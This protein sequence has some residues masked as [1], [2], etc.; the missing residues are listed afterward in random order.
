MVVYV[1]DEEKERDRCTGCGIC[2]GECPENAIYVTK[3]KI[4]ETDPETGESKEVPRPDIYKLNHNTCVFCGI[5]VEVCPFDALAMVGEYELSSYD[6]VDLI[7]DKNDMITHALRHG[8][9]KPWVKE[10]V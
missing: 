6:R 5:C 7:R 10:V 2:Q 9:T 4:E 3:T 8:L 1:F